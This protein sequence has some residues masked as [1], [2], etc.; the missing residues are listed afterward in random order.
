MSKSLDQREED[1]TF[2]CYGH[3]ERID[4]TRLKT[5][6]DERDYE[7][8]RRYR[9]ARR[10]WYNVVKDCKWKYGRSKRICA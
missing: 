6:V 10:R 5:K 1:N 8:H 2:R 4:D 3:A 9:R 7:E